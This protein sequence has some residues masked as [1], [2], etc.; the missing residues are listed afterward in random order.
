MPTQQHSIS[1]QGRTQT[2]LQ[3][4]NAMPCRSC[5]H[6]YSVSLSNV[7]LQPPGSCRCAGAYHAAQV[8]HTEQRSQHCL[9]HDAP[10]HKQAASLA[11]RTA[12]KK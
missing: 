10:A 6:C 12:H 7:S 1:T 9:S 3:L 4:D 2:M 11:P 5:M 8:P